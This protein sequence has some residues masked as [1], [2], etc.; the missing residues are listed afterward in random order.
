MTLSVLGGHSL[1]QAISGAMFR[2]RI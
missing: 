2:N 1:L